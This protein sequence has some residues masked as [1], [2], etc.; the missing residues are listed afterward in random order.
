MSMR[1]TLQV[2][3]AMVWARSVVLLVAGVAAIVVA[4]AYAFAIVVVSAADVSVPTVAVSAD[5]QALL[6]AADDLAP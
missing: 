6:A 3:S 1:A 2:F 5:S 4:A